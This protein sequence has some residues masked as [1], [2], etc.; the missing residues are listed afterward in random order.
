MK[1]NTLAVASARGWLGLVPFLLIVAAVASS[2]AT[3]QPGIWYALLTKPAWTP[4]NAVFP[5]AWTLLYLLVA[6]AGWRAWRRCRGSL[7]RI[8]FSIYGLQ[9]CLNLAWSWLFFGRHWIAL[10][11]IDMLLLV[12]AI[13]LNIRWFRMIDAWSARLL[14]PYLLWVLYAATLNAGI[15]WLN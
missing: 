6:I 3:F 4:P 5:V 1:D 8:A 13:T 2:G 15:L 12:A 7:R 9:L 11:L 14:M 10:G